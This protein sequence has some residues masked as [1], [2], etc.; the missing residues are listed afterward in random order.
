MKLEEGDRII[1]VAVCD[2]ADVCCRHCRR[3][4][5]PLP[6]DRRAHL[7]GSNPAGVRGIKLEGKDEVI[8]MA[9]LGHIEALPAERVAYVRQAN[10]MRGAV[11]DRRH[12]RAKATARAGSRA[13]A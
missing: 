5:D 3:A 1:G 10:M 9:I 7:Q 13:L 4:G 2:G 11:P 8:S 6:R 12:E